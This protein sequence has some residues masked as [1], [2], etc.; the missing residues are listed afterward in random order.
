MRR[1]ARFLGIAVLIALAVA[2]LS[3]VVMLLW[4]GV[5]PALFTGAHP[6]DYLHAVGLLVLSRILFGGLHR[7]GHWHGHR[8]FAKWQEMTGE[9]RERMVRCGPWARRLTAAPAPEPGPT[10]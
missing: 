9:E 8:H 1:M 7:H 10:S 6:I 4:N 2:L 5:V 3:E